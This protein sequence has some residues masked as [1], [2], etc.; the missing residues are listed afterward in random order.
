VVFWLQK[1]GYE[2]SDELVDRIFARAKS[3]A[4]VLTETEINELVEGK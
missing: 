2:P 4:T 1:R 3:S